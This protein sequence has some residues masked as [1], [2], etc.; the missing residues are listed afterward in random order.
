MKQEV[1]AAIDEL[2]RQ[3]V[4]SAVHITEDGSGGA[5]VFLE[6]ISIGPKFNP[7]ETWL[8]FHIP[9]LYP[10]A[11]IYPLFMAAN[12]VRADGSQFVAPIT[13]G[14]YFQGRPAL[15]IS[16]RTGSADTG[17]QKATTKVLKVLKFLE[18]IA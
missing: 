12:V 16:R 15:Q 7:T 1:S 4:S 18:Q 9:A 17:H 5:F 8:G 14:H 2:Q 6:P 13:P 11:D 10:Y 3:F